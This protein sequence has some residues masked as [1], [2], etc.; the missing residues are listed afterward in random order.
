MPYVDNFKQEDTM[1][2]T[3]EDLEERRHKKHESPRSRRGDDLGLK[4]N[5]AQRNKWS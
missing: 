3:E 1:V 4:E 2:V 5:M